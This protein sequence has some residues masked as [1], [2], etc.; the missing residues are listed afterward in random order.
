MPCPERFTALWV[1]LFDRHVG[2]AK[3]NDLLLAV[4]TGLHNRLLAARNLTLGFVACH[5]GLVD[6][7]HYKLPCSLTKTPYDKIIVSWFAAPVKASM[8]TPAVAIMPS[9]GMFIT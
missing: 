7:R 8:Y 6:L 5:L 9:S 2:I 4:L 3:T 1:R